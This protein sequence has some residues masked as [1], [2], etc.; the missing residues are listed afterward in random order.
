MYECII[1]HTQVRK[2]K[3]FKTQFHFI[4]KVILVLMKDG[5]RKQ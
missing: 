5:A 1:D 2:S 4:S 3:T